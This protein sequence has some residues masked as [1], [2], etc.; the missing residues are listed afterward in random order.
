MWQCWQRLLRLSGT[1]GPSGK[2]WS[3]WFAGLPQNTHTPPSLLRTV[4]LIF[5]QSLGSSLRRLDCLLHANSMHPPQLDSSIHAHILKHLT[6]PVLYL[7]A[8]LD[9]VALCGVKHIPRYARICTACHV[10]KSHAQALDREERLPQ[11]R[12][13]DH[14]SSSAHTF[15]IRVTTDR[16]ASSCARSVIAFSASMR[17][18]RY[19]SQTSSMNGS[20][21][22][23]DSQSSRIARDSLRCS[24]ATRNLSTAEVKPS[25]LIT[26]PPMRH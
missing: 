3:T 21:G 6:Q 7:I 9:E 11:C 1:W 23:S 10:L 16:P 15:A 13:V 26:A 20:P 25:T 22:S 4:C 2:I 12:I 14:S 24:S 17:E 19:V 8:L 18:D 5:A